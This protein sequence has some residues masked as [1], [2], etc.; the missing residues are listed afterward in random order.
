MEYRVKHPKGLAKK[1]RE[2][3]EGFGK[4]EAKEK[5]LGKMKG[6]HG[7]NLRP[8]SKEIFPKSDRSHTS[9]T[10]AGGLM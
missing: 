2:K 5:A 1:M 10:R 3:A 8:S 4:H 7:E 6:R 9:R